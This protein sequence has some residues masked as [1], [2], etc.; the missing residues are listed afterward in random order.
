MELT[1]HERANLLAEYKRH[2]RALSATEELVMTVHMDIDKVTHLIES[3]LIHLSEMNR[4]YHTLRED[5]NNV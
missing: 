4:I 3:R 5:V 2:Q 1:N